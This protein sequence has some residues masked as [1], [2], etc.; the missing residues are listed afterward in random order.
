MRRY[1]KLL[2][3][4]AVGLVTI[5]SRAVTP[6]EIAPGVS[7]PSDGDGIVYALLPDAPGTQL[8]RIKPHEAIIV[9][10]AGKN[11]V[12]SIV[13]KGP[14]VSSEVDG[15]RAELTVP[16]TKAVFYVRLNGDDPEI[17]FSRVHLLWLQPNRT[18]REISDFSAN[19][20]YGQRSRNVDEV[21]CNIER[22]PG[23]NWAKVTPRE[24]LLPG[25]FGMAFLPKDV[26]QFP[27]IVYDFSVPGDPSTQ[28]L[29]DAHGSGESAGGRSQQK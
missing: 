1:L 13:Y 18:R 22:L 11:L 25:E 5:S 4:T 21:P 16:S 12:R 7:L 27:D 20:F 17:Q 24:P 10:H 23:T 15:P 26:N 9:S 14:H 2:L 19:I 6:I 29:P 28:N 8:Q 3:C